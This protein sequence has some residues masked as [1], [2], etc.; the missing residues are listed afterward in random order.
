MSKKVLELKFGL[1]QQS[2]TLCLT[3]KAYR[4]TFKKITGSA[5]NMTAGGICTVL[6]M[7]GKHDRY[8]IGLN[9]EDILCDLDYNSISQYKGLLVHELNHLVTYHMNYFNFKCDEYR[10]T[11]LQYLYND[12]IRFVD[13]YLDY[14]GEEQNEK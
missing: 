3:N 2:L 5:E 13:H 1:T 4:K 11:L 14:L 10:S 9:A 6:S 8:I 12:T 7:P